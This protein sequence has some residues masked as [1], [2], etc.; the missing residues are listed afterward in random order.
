MARKAM[1][2]RGKRGQEGIRK[3]EYLKNKKSFLGKIKSIFHNFLRAFMWWKK[4]KKK[5]KNRGH[6]I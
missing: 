3:F 6:K 5:K 2:D 4:K 1:A